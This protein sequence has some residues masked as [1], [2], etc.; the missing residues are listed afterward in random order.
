MMDISPSGKHYAFEPLPHLAQ[1]LRE[2]FPQVTVQQ[3]ALSDRSGE[4]EFL[5]VENDPG[6]SGLQ[7]RFYGRPDPKIRRIPVR[8]A[9]LDEMIPQ[10]ERIGFIKM[11]IE[12][13]EFHAMKG[14]VETI[15]RCQPTTFIR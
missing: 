12:G 9:T 14:G 8:V 13:G 4:S 6:Y 7:R 15:R 10:D 11:D 3:V 2:K 5:F 1:E